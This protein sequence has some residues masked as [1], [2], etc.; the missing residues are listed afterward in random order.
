MRV[1]E[2]LD[3]IESNLTS[4]FHHKQHSPIGFDIIFAHLLEQA[5]SLGLNLPLG[6]EH[7]DTFIQK[8]ELEL[9][10]YLS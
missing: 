7:F 2:G 8:R 1:I 5:Q 9:Q 4:A 10:R 6:G 3:Y